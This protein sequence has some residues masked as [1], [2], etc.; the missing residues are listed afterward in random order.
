LWFFFDDFD[1]LNLPASALFEPHVGHWS[2]SPFLVFVTLRSLFGIDSYAIF[3]IPV[4]IAHL[5]LV[6]VTWRAMNRA[7]VHP[8][9]ATSAALVV[10]ASGPGHQN[11]VW[12]FQVGFI[13]ALALGMFAILLA[14]RSDASV[15]RLV[16]VAALALA[17]VTFSSTALPVLVALSVMMLK[18]HGMRRAIAV[19]APAVLA[20][21]VWYVAIGRHGPRT[22]AP[23]ELRQLLVDVPVFVLHMLVRGFGALSPVSTVGIVLAAALLG[24]GVI[25]ARRSGGRE[26]I[27]YLYALIVPVF[28]LAAGASRIGL[29][30]HTA[31]ESRYVYLVVGLLIPLA[32]LAV[33]QLAQRLGSRV[34]FAIGAIAFAGLACVGAIQLTRG[35]D[36]RGEVTTAVREGASAVIIR[37]E[38]RP[39]TP[40]DPQALPFASEAPQITLGDIVR[41]HDQGWFTPVPVA[42]DRVQQVWSSWG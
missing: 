16:A 21:G 5:A 4:V 10:L 17:S 30:V 38:E 2:T 23:E 19:V 35:L 37:L 34:A 13:G 28:A 32:A 20:Y 41:W 14:D 22:G 27:V 36:A 12:A 33:D 18:R 15:S 26:L 9:I 39:H 40:Y 42:P 31:V 29:G 7:G 1:F 11:M 3:V 25:T 6:H 24:W 8:W